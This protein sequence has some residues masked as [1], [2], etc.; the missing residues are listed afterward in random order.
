MQTMPAMSAKAA[1]N[2]LRMLKENPMLRF[3]PT[4]GLLWPQMANAVVYDSK[5]LISSNNT[6]LD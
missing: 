6:I 3:T 2:F 1:E 4:L 5:N